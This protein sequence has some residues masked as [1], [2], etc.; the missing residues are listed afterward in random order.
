[1][2]SSRPSP[3]TSGSVRRTLT[4]VAQ[5]GE[6]QLSATWM[7]DGTPDTAPDSQSLDTLFTDAV[8]LVRRAG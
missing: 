2:P 1:M 3:Q 5:I 8:L 4:L 7:Q 6:V